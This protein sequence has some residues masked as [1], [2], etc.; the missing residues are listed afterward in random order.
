MDAALPED[1]V[2]E[3]DL[4]DEAET[5]EPL[6]DDGLFGLRP[7]NGSERGVGGSL[8]AVCCCFCWFC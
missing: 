7:S 3:A 1:F 5:V 6:D 4:E 2:E 8:W